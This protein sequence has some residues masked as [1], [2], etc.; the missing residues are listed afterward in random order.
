M[1]LPAAS[2]L[3][4]GSHDAMTRR[5]AAADLVRALVSSGLEAETT[6]VRFDRSDVTIRPGKTDGSVSLYSFTPSGMRS[7]VCLGV[8]VPL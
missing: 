8:R 1:S 6:D 4:L 7:G 3:G 5:Q 2:G